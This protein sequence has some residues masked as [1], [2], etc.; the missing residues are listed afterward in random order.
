MVIRRRGDGRSRLPPAALYHAGG[1]LSGPSLEGHGPGLLAP[2]AHSGPVWRG[3]G[4][5]PESSEGRP[6]SAPWRY[7][8]GSTQGACPP[9]RVAPAER[10]RCTSDAEARM[11]PL[12]T[13]ASITPDWRRCHFARLAGVGCHLRNPCVR[14]ML[15]PPAESSVSP[16]YKGL[17]ISGAAEVS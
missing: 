9:H 5:R 10:A 17:S 13:G 6:A 1:R 12:H 3:V 7:P 11:H 2:S 4:A 14:R 8:F 16:R 15:Q